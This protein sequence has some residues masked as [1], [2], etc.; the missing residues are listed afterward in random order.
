[1][2]AFQ[3]SARLLMLSGVA[4]LVA[5]GSDGGDGVNGGNGLPAVRTPQ[6]I[7]YI[8]SATNTKLMA[9]ND[10]GSITPFALV[11]VTGG[12]IVKNSLKQ[13][14]DGLHIAYVVS[15]GSTD[16][17]FIS[18][19]NGAYNEQVTT[20]PADRDVNNVHWSPGSNKLI[21]LADAN[22]NDQYE[23]FMA[24]LAVNANGPVISIEVV[25]GT[26]NSSAALDIAS[27]SWSPDGSKIAY[28]VTD[29]RRTTPRKTIG[30]NYHDVSIG[31]RHSVR[32]SPAFASYQELFSYTWAPDSNHLAYLSDDVTD[33]KLRAFK[34]TFG[35]GSFTRTV[36]P[37]QPGFSVTGIAY[38]SDSRHLA[39]RSYNTATG[40][41]R[42]VTEAPDDVAFTIHDNIGAINKFSW[43]HNNGNV[44]AYISNDSAGTSRL[45]RLDVSTGI[46]TELNTT[47]EIGHS[48]KVL[49]W[50]PNDDYI[51]YLSGPDRYVQNLHLVD[52]VNPVPILVQDGNTGEPAFAP[53][54]WSNAGD[55]F[56]HTV[57]DGSVF[58]YSLASPGQST[59]VVGP[60]TATY[61]SGAI[62]SDDDVKLIVSG[63]GGGACV[64]D[65]LISKTTENNVQTVSDVECRSVFLY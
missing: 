47:R 29:S 65:L 5:C 3:S 38:S 22:V 41:F 1:M 56:S 35:A 23:L 28:T 32:L 36:R 39:S 61:F 63:G 55:R 2:R 58:V 51:A 34:I 9:A 20:L 21:Y 45:Y 19:V 44:L 18:H 13:S 49:D 7:I 40:E 4:V 48:I 12:T 16:N 25:S 8:D 50:A 26:V 11:S 33:N 31:S 57:D 6:S 27:P 37:A 15:N 10:E 14:P 64:T 42:L 54:A 53:L 43:S 59:E 62:W 30:I 60:Y 24:T 52:P 17:L 46:K